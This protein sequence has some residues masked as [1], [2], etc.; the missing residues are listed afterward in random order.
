MC[1]Q[2]NNEMDPQRSER[3]MNIPAGPEELTAGWLTTALRQG[4]AIHKAAVASFQAGP[5]AENRGFFGQIARL[6][7]DYDRGEAGAPRSLIAK[8]ASAIPEMRNRAIDS[9]E[10]EVR[11]YQQLAHQTNLRTPT[12]YYGDINTETG[13]H[14]LLLEDLAPARSGSRVAGCSR[15][16]AEL[17]VHQI[18][19]FHAAWWEKPQLGEISW[20]PDT[21]VD[22]DPGALKEQYDRWWP[23]F[24]ERANHRLPD[25]LKD[26]G[27]R[28]GGY[29]ANLRRRLFGSP[30]QTLI[31]RDYQLDNLFFGAPE[32][33]IPFAVVDWQFI[34]R[35][36]GVWDV[37]Y[38]LSE[39]LHPEERRAIEMD[40]LGAYRQILIDH[41]VQGYTLEQCLQDYRLSLLQRFTALVSTIAAMPFSNEQRQLHI[42]ILLPRN[43]A[44]ILDHH[45]GELLS[46]MTG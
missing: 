8:F 28:L 44:A 11:F 10:R 30:P 13:V 3:L 16:Q 22:L 23:Q 29:R 1:H 46:L 42:D 5:L 6:H 34:S 24:L 37:A 41:G 43:N 35:G 4:G 38:F 12:C 39:S 31:H 33:G 15:E 9:Y 17:A 19:R 18:A 45:A 26:I 32:G 25:P 2:G 14:I 21:N 40:L 36:R 20:L 27:E 7:L